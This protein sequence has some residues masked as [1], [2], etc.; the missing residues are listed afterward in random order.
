MSQDERRLSF[1]LSEQ[2][3]A[4]RDLARRFAEQ[5][6]RPVAR[7]FEQDIEGKLA[8]RIIDRAAEV[9]LLGLPVPREFG[10]SGGSNVECSLVL[11]EL[12]V[13]C[14]GIATAIGASWFGQTPIMMAATREHF[15]NVRVDEVIGTATNREDPGTNGLTVDATSVFWTT[16]TVP[17]TV[18]RAT[19]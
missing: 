18:M 16:Y 8:E 4:I 17:G 7:Q 1:L 12:A 14:G 6:I 10:G 9:G 11:E 3:E 13:G 19:K 5:E 15:G 2:Q